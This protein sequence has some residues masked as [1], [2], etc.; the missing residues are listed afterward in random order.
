MISH[1]QPNSLLFHINHHKGAL[2]QPYSGKLNL[3]SN[4]SIIAVFRV[5]WHKHLSG[6][7]KQ[8][9]RACQLGKTWNHGAIKSDISN[10]KVNS[11]FQMHF[12]E[13]RSSRG[14]IH[15]KW[16]WLASSLC[17]PYALLNFNLLSVITNKYVRGFHT[18]LSDRLSRLSIQCIYSRCTDHS[19]SLF[20]LFIYSMQCL[21][22][23]AISLL[24]V[25]VLE[26]FFFLHMSSFLT[27]RST[28]VT[29]GLKLN[30]QNTET[31]RETDW[32]QHDCRRLFQIGP[33]ALFS[34]N[35]SSAVRV[36]LL[37]YN[38]LLI[39]CVMNYIVLFIIIG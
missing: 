35:V 28:R 2:Y 9:S 39:A 14:F 37:V 38:L 6:C 31:R 27:L 12:L 36:P 30:K 13:D 17:L 25:V 20:C 22:A 8:H 26:G 11:V 19:N 24:L 10:G 4:I 21:I 1:T 32:S 16:Q 33:Q 18:G 3:Q 7:G 23:A 34:H 15:C 5:L 29:Q